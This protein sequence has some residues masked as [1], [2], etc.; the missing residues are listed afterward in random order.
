MEDKSLL[1]SII[2]FIG[3]KLTTLNYYILSINNRSPCTAHKKTQ[4][5]YSFRSYMGVSVR[6]YSSVENFLVRIAAKKDLNRFVLWV[7][8]GY[9]QNNRILKHFF[10][11]SFLKGYVITLIDF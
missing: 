1:V 3:E 2:F 7:D 6:H 8:R 10:H 4:K 11:F 9:I 5:D